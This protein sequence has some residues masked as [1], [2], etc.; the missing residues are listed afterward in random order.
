MLFA[1]FG[2]PEEFIEETGAAA[3]SALPFTQEQGYEDT[4]MQAGTS[5]LGLCFCPAHSPRGVSHGY[6]GEAKIESNDVHNI[7][8]CRQAGER[9]SLS[10]AAMQHLLGTAGAA[11]DSGLAWAGASHWRYR[12]RAAVKPAT[13]A[14]EMPEAT[15]KASSK[16][17]HLVP[18]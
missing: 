5:S 18:A 13:T 11:V 3:D 6:N 7:C 1:D 9:L 10:Q 15:F 14:E 2:A 17:G 12:T 8:G 16:C 4:S